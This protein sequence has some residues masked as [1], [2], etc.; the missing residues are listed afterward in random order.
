MTKE[1]DKVLAFALEIIATAAKQSQI[2]RTG[3]SDA[4]EFARLLRAKAKEIRE[5][6]ATPAK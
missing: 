2:N 6:S 3:A 1:E 5:H 4:D